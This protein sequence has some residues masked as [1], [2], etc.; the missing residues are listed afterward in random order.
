[1]P[2]S[3]T[4]IQSTYETKRI[5]F[6]TNPENRDSYSDKDFHLT[7]MMVSVV[8]SPGEDG[9]RFFVKTRPGLTPYQVGEVGE[10]RAIYWWNVP[11]KIVSVVGS[12][13]YFGLTLLF[14]LTTGS[15]YVGITEHLDQDA[16]RT[17]FICDGNQGWVVKADGTY[18][19]CIPDNWLPTQA[20]ALTDAVT[21][22]PANN[23]VYDVTVAGTTGSS[24]PVW[25]TTVGATVTNGTVTF[26]CREQAFPSPHIPQPIFLDG[27]MF[28]AKRGTQD[29]YNSQL[30]YPWKWDAGNFLSAEMYADNVVALAKNNNMIYAIGEQSVQFLYDNANPTG[31]P[32]LNNPGAVLQFGTPAMGTVVQTEEEVILVGNTGNGGHSVW[33]INGFK[34]KEIS[35]PAV[36]SVL[37][38]DIYLAQAVATCV[39]VAGQKLYV[40]S[41]TDKTLVYSFT[42]NTWTEWQGPNYTTFQAQ[43][44]SDFIS[45]SPLW[46]DRTNGK[47]YVQNAEGSYLD[48]GLFYHCRIMTPKLDFDSLNRKT[49]SRFSI[50]G[51]IPDTTPQVTISWSDDDY[52]TWSS[53]RTLNYTGDLPSIRQLGD[54]R[55]RAFKID[56]VYNGLIRLEGIEVD[57]NKGIR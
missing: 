27:Y 4:P 37:D 41:T 19:K 25:P 24:Q 1:V 54:F 15:G 3:K 11:S 26:T 53:W 29:V 21:P 34:A 45:G 16:L 2:F 51:D 8:K 22:S 6:I 55:R 31:T 44:S 49:M 13:V 50:V 32:L 23:Y 43:Y 36:D 38:Q 18:R 30:N 57:I 40:L 9:K 7:N 12:N 39:R 10:G 56:F 28:L 48:D 35:I 5:A 17:L 47:I 20:Y 33:T 42:T 46:L 52:K 14:S